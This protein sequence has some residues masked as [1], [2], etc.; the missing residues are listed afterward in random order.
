MSFETVFSL[1]IIFIGLLG[2]YNLMLY[3]LPLR[4]TI[5]Y[6]DIE[7]AEA[8]VFSRSTFDHVF[9]GSG[10]IGHIDPRIS[11]NSFN[12]YFPYYG[13]CTGLQVIALSNKTPKVLFVETNFIFKGTNEKVIAHLFS[14]RL[15]KWKQIL[16]FIL[17]KNNPLKLVK[18]VLRAFKIGMNSRK[19]SGSNTCQVEIEELIEQFNKT[20]DLRKLQSDLASLK[21]NVDTLSDKGCEVVFLEVPIDPVLANAKLFQIQH[22]ELKKIFREKPYKWIPDS[23]GYYYRTEDGLHLTSDSLQTFKNHLQKEISKLNI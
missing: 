16:P 7:R 8:Y 5:Y 3:I 11:R 21:K 17:K 22:A 20:P 1:C 14:N 2:I 13:S 6:D 19:P 18:Q 10:L 4:K 23:R 9:V 12:L 15:F